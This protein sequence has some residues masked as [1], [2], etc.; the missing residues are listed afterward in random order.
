[1]L[2][3]ARI[4]AQTNSSFILNPAE[5]HER[6]LP[7]QA[8]SLQPKK[9]DLR[10]PLGGEWSEKKRKEFLCRDQFYIIIS[11]DGMKCTL[12]AWLNCQSWPFLDLLSYLLSS[13][14][15]LWCSW[16]PWNQTGK[17]SSISGRKSPR[18]CT[19]TCIWSR[20]VGSRLETTQRVSLVFEKDEKE[21]ED[22]DK[23][24]RHGMQERLM[25][26]CSFY[27]MH[28]LYLIYTNLYREFSLAIQWTADQLSNYC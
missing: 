10:P 20:L 18:S 6:L 23:S 1:M 21:S 15:R 4:W 2:T 28:D 7:L 3:C 13:W 26:Q 27:G 9:P 14:A 16:A 22:G 25:Q 17:A 24:W 11:S 19:P 5:Q 12:L 8:A